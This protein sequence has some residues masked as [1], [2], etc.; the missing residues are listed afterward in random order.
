[1]AVGRGGVVTAKRGFFVGDM[2]H[3]FLA[4]FDGGLHLFNRPEFFGKLKLPVVANHITFVLLS[5]ATWY[6][7][8]ALFGWLLQ[9]AW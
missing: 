9:A 5:A 8:H 4:L 3:G 7:Y 1:M 2:L 6:G